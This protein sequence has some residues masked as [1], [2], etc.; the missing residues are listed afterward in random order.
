MGKNKRIAISEDWVATIVG[1]G[2][3]FLAILAFSLGGYSLAPVNYKWSSGGDLLALFNADNLF[4]V[5][6]QFVIS[7]VAVIGIFVAMGK[8]VKSTVGFIP[9]FIIAVVAQL[10]GGNTIINDLGLEAVIFS[11]LIGLLINNIWGTPKWIKPALASELYVKIGLIFLGA[12]ILFQDILKSGVYGLLQAVI[13]VFTV[14][15]FAFWLFRKLKIDKELS[16]MMASGVSICGVAAAVASAGAIKGD[17]KKLSFVVSLVLVIAVPMIVL[18]P[19]LAHLLGLNDTLAGAW[20]GGTIDT[21]GAVVATGTLYG[22]QAVKIATIVK[23]SQNVLLGIAAFA[24]AVYW[25]ATN[26]DKKGL[27]GEKPSAKLL[28][29]RFPKFVLGFVFA[30]FVF[31]LFFGGENYQPLVKS[32]KSFQTLFFTLGFVSIGLETNFRSLVN[33]EHKKATWAFIGAQTFNV[34]FTLVV[35]LVI[36]GIF[37]K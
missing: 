24:I 28:W 33:K 3:I 5:A 4:R 18:M 34:A 23:F 25:A 10:I 6:C 2:L 19:F 27:D 11:L 20:I 12:T 32:M 21:T 16:L 8:P 13:V 15:N 17:P 35:A 1:L 22:E 31:S 26:Q 37:A 14:W 30:S 7:Y 29:A 9:V 36:F